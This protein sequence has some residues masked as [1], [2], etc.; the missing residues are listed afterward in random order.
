LSSL[1]QEEQEAEIRSGYEL[2]KTFNVSKSSVFSLPFGGLKDL[3]D[4]TI[5]IIAKY[6]YKGILFAND[7]IN[8]ASV[9]NSASITLPLRTRS[10]TWSLIRSRA[11]RGRFSKPPREPCRS[12]SDSRISV[13]PGAAQPGSSYFN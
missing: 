5:E 9:I 10:A 6:G 8:L 4:S 7:L 1:S 2:I 13:D 12:E 3:N 11:F